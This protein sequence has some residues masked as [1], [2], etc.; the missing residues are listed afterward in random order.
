MIASGDVFASKYMNMY[1]RCFLRHGMTYIFPMQLFF[2]FM[3]R[4]K[5]CF[6]GRPAFPIA[7]TY[8][9]YR[10]FVMCPAKVAWPQRMP[11]NVC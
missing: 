11:L 5:V 4:K 1:Q 3:H 9:M 10:K 6:R 7:E 8:R 2:L